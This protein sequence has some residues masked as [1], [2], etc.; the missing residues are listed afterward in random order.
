MVVRT[1]SPLYNKI[2]SI[3]ATQRSGNCATPLIKTL[4]GRNKPN[5]SELLPLSAQRQAITVLL[6]N[7]QIASLRL[8]QH[9]ARSAGAS[10]EGTSD[11]YRPLHAHPKM[12]WLRDA[13]T[14]CFQQ[15]DAL[16]MFLCH[17]HARD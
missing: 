14:T 11:S 4:L 15:Q 9:G 7:I 10:T 5:S 6:G 3:S 12:M 8:D 1:N 13:L 2:L 17:Q 16:L